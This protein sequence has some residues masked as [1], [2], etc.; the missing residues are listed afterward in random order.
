M[1]ANIEGIGCILN[2]EVPPKLEYADNPPSGK[3][4]RRARR[5]YELRK[6]K[7]KL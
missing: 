5:K 3:E 4:K 1:Y 7:G 2:Y 6:R